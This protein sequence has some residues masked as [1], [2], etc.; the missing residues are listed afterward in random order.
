[1]LDSVLVSAVHSEES[2]VAGELLRRRAP[3]QY[4]RTSR[5]LAPARRGAART[6]RKKSVSGGLAG[7]PSAALRA[8]GRLARRARTDR[9]RFCLT[10]LP[11]L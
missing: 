5:A 7:A 6:C 11:K 3:T 4:N 10:L 8:A 9:T 1:M 2:T